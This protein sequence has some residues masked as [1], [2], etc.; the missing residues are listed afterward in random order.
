MGSLNRNSLKK[1]ELCCFRSYSHLLFYPSSRNLIIGNNGQGK[2]NLLEALALLFTGN[3]FRVFSPHSLVQEG[4]SFA[5]VSAEISRGKEKSEV[6]LVLG[7]PGKKQLWVNNKKAS[8]SFLAQQ[9]PLVVF[10]P[11]S[12]S[13]LKSS[14]ENRR[15]WLD[16]WLSTRGESSISREF[17]TVLLQKNKLLKQIKKSLISKIRAQTLLESLNEIFIE[18]SLLLARTRVSALKSLESFL[19]EGSDCIFRNFGQVNGKK[20]KIGLSY[21]MKG[22]RQEEGSFVEKERFFRREGPKRL[23]LEAKSGLSLYGA[24][25]DDFKLFFQ[26]KDS[27]YFCSQGQQRALLLALKVAQILWLSQV[28][29]KDG[30]LLLLDDVFSEIDKHLIFNLLQFLNEIPSQ[31]VLTSTNIPSF[32]DWKKFQIFNLKKGVLRKENKSGRENRDAAHYQL[33]P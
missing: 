1:L 23:F 14:A 16:S 27:R 4:K 21:V 29:K 33:S 3:S 26:G 30:L 10:N 28:Q 11:E 31:I 13:L 2:T 15:W 12:L 6:K 18:K 7:N 32:L 9:V 19:K 24:H 25:R 5:A 8:F 22:E 20:I 17:K